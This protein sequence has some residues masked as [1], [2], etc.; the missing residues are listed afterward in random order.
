MNIAIIPARGGSKRIPKKNVKFFCGKPIIAYSIEAAKESNIFEQIFVSSEDKKILSIAEKYGANCIK[1]PKELADD[2]TPM[3]DVIIHSINEFMIKNN[4]K[5]EAVCSI[6]ATAPLLQPSKLIEGYKI[7]KSDNWEYVFPATKYN[8]PVY[9]SFIKNQKNGLEMLFSKSFDSRSQ[10]L[11]EVYHDAGQFCWG[12]VDTWLNIDKSITKKSTIV[13][14]DSS[15]VTDIDN[16]SDWEF[17]EFQYE[18]F[19]SK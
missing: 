17:A 4:S 7:L 2:Y 16:D 15:K 9:R 13:E 1:R 11:P 3:R 14:I 8:Y 19:H 18:Y 12:S 10:D 5:P 6:F